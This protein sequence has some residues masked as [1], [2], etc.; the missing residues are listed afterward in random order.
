MKS[1]EPVFL[2]A[3]WKYLAMLNY[4]VNPMVLS[5]FLPQGTELD[6]WQGKYF[7]SVVGFLFQNAKFGRLS[8]PF[9]RNFEEVNLRFYVKRLSENEWR[10]GVVFIKEIVPRWAIAWTA[11]TFYNENYVALPMSHKILYEA[12]GSVSEV[13]YAWKLPGGP[14]NHLVVVVKGEPA[15]AEVN[16]QAEF[17]TEHYWGYARQRDGGTLEY[18]VEHSKWKIWPIETARLD[19]DVRE[20]YGDKFGAYLKNPPV[21]A[22]LAEGS[23]VSVFKGNRIE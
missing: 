15:A 23:A 14:R 21:S 20:L 10:R 13:S 11:R 1:K 8:V 2:T 16:S 12:S 7:V 9:H 19:C 4:E 22:F 17:I 18:Q 6:Q 3:D 5:P